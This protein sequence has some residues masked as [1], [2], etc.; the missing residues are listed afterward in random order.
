MEKFNYTNG[1]IQRS[2]GKETILK[3]RKVIS[4]QLLHNSE[5]RI[6][7]G[8]YITSPHANEMNFIICSSAQE[9]RQK[10]NTETN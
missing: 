3:F 10:T 7:D 9:N 5:K 6:T 1:I 8:R 2:V 4:V